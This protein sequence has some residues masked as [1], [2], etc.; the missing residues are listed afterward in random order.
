MI[1]VSFTGSNLLADVSRVHMTTMKASHIQR[2]SVWHALVWPTGC[3]PSHIG[4]PNFFK[5]S[6]DTALAPVENGTTALNLASNV[7]NR[8]HFPL[9]PLFSVAILGVYVLLNRNQHRRH[10]QMFCRTKTKVPKYGGRAL[11]TYCDIQFQ[12]LLSSF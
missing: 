8:I 1:L 9:S 2:G 12:P 3:H 4:C 5:Y 11:S 10:G 7:S 6:G